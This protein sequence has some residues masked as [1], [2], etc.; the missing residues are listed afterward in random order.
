MSTEIRR[1]RGI[2][3]RFFRFMWRSLK[4]INTLVF[5]LLLISLMVFAI[6]SLIDRSGPA[7]LAGS[8][9]VVNPAGVLVE[10]LTTVSAAATLVQGRKL[11]QQT[12]VKDLID[13]LALARDDNRIELV[14]LNLD[15]LEQGLLPKLTRIAD[16]ITEF[17]TSGKKVI[18]VANS[19]SQS[20]LYIAAHADEVLLNPE[21][22]ALPE[23]FSMHLT[24]FKS[25]LEDAD[26]SVNV[27]RV[28]KYKSATEPYFRDNMSD[29]DR[30]ARLAIL[31]EWWKTYTSGVEAARGMVSGSIDAMLQNAPKELRLVQGGL[32]RLSLEKG[33][34][35]RLVTNSERRSYLMELAGKDADGNNFRGITYKNYL[36]AARQTVKHKAGK[37]AVLT[38]VGPILDGEASAGEIGSESLSKLIRKARLDENTEAIVLRIDSGGGSKSASEIIRTE[39]LAAQQSGIPVIVSMGSVA[40]SGG[41]WI[42]ASSDEIWATPTTIT[43]SI[44]IYGLFPSFENTLAQYG[45]YSDGVATTPIAGGASVMRGVSPEYGDV[46]QILIEAGYEQFLTTVADGRGMSV[47]EVNEVAQGRIW[48][49]KKAQEL[50]LVDELGDLEQAIASAAK[51]AEIKDYSVWYVEPERSF[52]EMLLQKISKRVSAALPQTGTD[53]VRQIIGKLSHELGYWG[54]LNDP[55]SAYV[56]CGDCP[57]RP[58]QW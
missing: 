56:I 55:Q 15:K 26:V 36:N 4:A 20:A 43:G 38:A 3:A 57:Q 40:A 41:Y 18:A 42:A 45:V 25:L 35:D 54:R 34:V 51:L 47:E 7:V 37:I 23:G 9:L 32:A 19:Y 50:G 28:G 2:I 33:L 8:A 27:F 31:N 12:L 58:W 22:L 46:L 16:A 52:E 14:V 11:P 49:G 6:F 53:P 48:T 29:E 1:E 30:E 17:K 39:L 44:G 24:Y 5:G 21:G 13:S 10:Q